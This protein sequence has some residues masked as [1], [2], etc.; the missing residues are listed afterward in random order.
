MRFLSLL[1]L[2]VLAA[3]AQKPELT[4]KDV[5]YAERPDGN[6]KLD[7]WIPDGPGPHPVAIIVH[8][9]GWRNGDKQT[10]V[11]PLFPILTQ[12]KFAWF[13]IDYRL[14]PAHHFPDPANDVVDAIRWVKANA[15]K[16]RVDP[17]RVVLMGES[18][19]G[20]LVSWIGVTQGNALGLKAV[21]PIYAPHD[22][23]ARAEKGG[24]TENV[25]LYLNIGAELNDKTRAAM[26]AASPA[27]FVKKGLPPFLLI[28]GTKDA[29]V[30]YW[31][32]VDMQKRMKEA[33]NICDLFAV[34][35]G[36]HGMASWAKL[37]PAWKAYLAQWLKTHVAGPRS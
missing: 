1:F 12:A 28:H 5:V 17:S 33:G 36:A 30:P 27:G 8:G 26:K 18:A 3:S 14:A 25:Q 7:A 20:Q 31:L 22:L 19:G 16:Y 32:S 35:E 10:Y 9:G 29:A 6:L 21:V 13:T 11:Q 4:L 37:D 15:K 24:I 2:T 34:A 23:L